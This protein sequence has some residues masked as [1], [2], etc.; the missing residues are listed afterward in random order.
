[1]TTYTYDG[2]E[3]TV[4]EM[5]YPDGKIKGS[6]LLE[7]LA[8]IVGI[9][10]LDPDSREGIDFIEVGADDLQGVLSPTHMSGR[11]IVLS[12]SGVLEYYGV[13]LRQDAPHQDHQL[14]D[15]LLHE[16]VAGM[17]RFGMVKRSEI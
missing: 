14:L 11:H 6:V 8:P 13:R 7:Q 16:L 10:D 9:T 12:Y 15:W 4:F 5:L 1:M 17:V 3:V 2:H